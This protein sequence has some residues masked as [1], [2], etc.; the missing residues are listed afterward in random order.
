LTVPD[1]LSDRERE[2]ITELA[3]LRAAR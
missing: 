2:L 3:S 1:D